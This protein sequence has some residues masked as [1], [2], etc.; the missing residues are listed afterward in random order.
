MR[1]ANILRSEVADVTSK[2]QLESPACPIPRSRSFG[3]RTFAPSQAKDWKKISWVD[4]TRRVPQA[5][6]ID[7]R[8]GGMQRL[9]VELEHA[10]DKIG[11][12]RVEFGVR[13]GLIDPA[14]ALCGV[15]VEVVRAE[16]DFQRARPANQERQTSKRSA[17][18]INRSNLRLSEYA[19]SRLAKP[20]SQ[21]KANSLPP[22]ELF[23]V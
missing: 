23:R 17:P 15:G 16:N 11:D 13:Q 6:V 2:I 4:L 21:P 3:I 9:R 19:F 18:G 8:L 5:G 12:E 7:D 10:A 22:P 20:I 14:V 1:G